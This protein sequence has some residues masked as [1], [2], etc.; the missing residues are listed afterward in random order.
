MAYMN[1][2]KKAAIKAAID[3]VIAKSGHKVKY[4][5]TC[6]HS[7]IKLAIL[8]CDIDLI[9]NYNECA[10]I[11][12]NRRGEQFHE[13]KDGYVQV[14]NYHIDNW[15]TGAACELMKA[16]SAALDTGNYNNS[17]LQSDF[18]DVGHYSYLHL[19]K[20]NRP[21]IALAA[22]TSSK[23]NAKQFARDQILKMMADYNITVQDLV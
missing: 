10:R 7:S 15:F 20:W 9:A 8:Q 6:D 14:N 3:E 11:V 22:K 1:Q 17:D 5:L 23:D 12:S 18:F 19:G 2:A 4:S 13:V 21:F 16:L